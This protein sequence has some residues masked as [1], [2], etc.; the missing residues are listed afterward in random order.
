M[1]DAK[2]EDKICDKCKSMK[3][4]R[5]EVQRTVYGD[6]DAGSVTICDLCPRCEKLVDNAIKRAVK[7]KRGPRPR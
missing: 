1:A 2:P 3:A 4:R 7:P 6:A 5:Q